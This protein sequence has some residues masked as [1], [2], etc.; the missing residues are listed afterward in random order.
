MA[1]KNMK[2]AVFAAIATAGLAAFSLFGSHSAA[3]AGGMWNDGTKGSYKDG[4]SAP[5]YDWAFGAGF[6]FKPKYEGSKEHDFYGFP[7][8]FPT[9]TKHYGTGLFSRIKVRSFDDI[10]YQLI[11]F[12]GLEIGPVAGYHFG[13]DQNDA[14]RLNGMGDVDGGLVVGG[15]VGY[16][17]QNFLFDVAYL[18]QVTGDDTGY[19][20]RFG[21]EADLPVNRNVS[22][23]ARVGATFA[24]DDYMS[25]YFGVSAAQS[26]NSGLAAYN[27]DAGIKDVHF[28]LG[29]K[30]WLAERWHLKA[31][32]RYSRLL[33]DATNSSVV[34]T[35]DQF[36]GHIAL[37]YSF[38]LGR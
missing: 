35:P 37:G 8:I 28:E 20:I 1:K 30:L 27:A 38:S 24:D 13:R 16:R 10:R 21:V 31:S 23:T 6:A 25:T 7:I 9:K 26:A 14:R 4:A 34:E 12:Q 5:A 15:Y 22:L 3:Q 17:I 11:R 36:S 2:N 19:R 33:S 29:A 32:G 18:D